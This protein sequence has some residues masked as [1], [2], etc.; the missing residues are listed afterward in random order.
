[1]GGADGGFVIERQGHLDS[2]LT[3]RFSLKG[4]AKSGAKRDYALT[5]NN[6]PLV[7]EGL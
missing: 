6:K 5:V 2:D 7:R 3:V 4:T 1:V